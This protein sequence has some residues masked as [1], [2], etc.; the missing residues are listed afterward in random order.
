MAS[1]SHKIHV[2]ILNREVIAIPPHTHYNPIL[3]SLLIL[4]QNV[5]FR[6]SALE[7]VYPISSPVRLQ[8]QSSIQSSFSILSRDFSGLD[9]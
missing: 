8:F 6:G 5:D 3:S 7:P 2:R 1:P 9:Y 4:P